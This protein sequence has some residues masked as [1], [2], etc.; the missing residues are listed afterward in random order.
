MASQNVARLAEELLS[1][2]HQE[3][4]ELVARIRNIIYPIISIQIQPPS[5]SNVK[6]SFDAV[7]GDSVPMLVAPTPTPTP[8]K[9]LQVTINPKVCCLLCKNGVKGPSE[10]CFVFTL[11]HAPQ[12]KLIV[13][14]FC[15]FTSMKERNKPGTIFNSIGQIYTE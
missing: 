11:P 5:L 7:C 3:N 8:I 9:P 13:C 12:V 2:C 10:D 1:A 15:I 6:W 14:A 4:V